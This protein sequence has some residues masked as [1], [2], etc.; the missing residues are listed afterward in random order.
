MR[1][2]NDVPY[3]EEPYLD[4]TRTYEVAQS[5]CESI[6]DTLITD[7][8]SIEDFAVKEYPDNI[9]YTKGRVTQ[10]AVWALLADMY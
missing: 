4:D 10:K 1:A 9:D 8:K 3:V 6:L 7:L 2:F 5:T